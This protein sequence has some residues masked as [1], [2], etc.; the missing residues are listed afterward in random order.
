MLNLLCSVV[1]FKS[2]KGVLVL[3]FPHINYIMY[4]DWSS[5]EIA[6]I[7]FN[8]DVDNFNNPF[9]RFLFFPN[10]IEIFIGFILL[11][12]SYFYLYNMLKSLSKDYDN[13]FCFEADKFTELILTH[14]LVLQMRSNSLKFCLYS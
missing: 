9:L 5:F 3:Y 14:G 2:I 4:N 13:Y 11:N 7:Y 10:F 1:D 12:A 8:Y 6:A